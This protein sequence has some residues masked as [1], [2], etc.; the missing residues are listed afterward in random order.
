MAGVKRLELHTVAS[1]SMCTAWTRP[2]GGEVIQIDVVGRN[3][4]NVNNLWQNKK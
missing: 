1:A 3:F 4:D 2:E